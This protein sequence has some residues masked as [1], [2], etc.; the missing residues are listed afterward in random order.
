VGSKKEGS[1]GE[2]LKERFGEE[3]RS[4]VFEGCGVKLDTI[5]EVIKVSVCA[6]IKIYIEI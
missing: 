1:E 2:N 3:K 5:G 6:K 4:G